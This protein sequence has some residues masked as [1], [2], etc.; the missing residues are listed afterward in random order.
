MLLAL[1]AIGAFGLWTPDKDRAWLERK[2]LA[3]PGDMVQVAGMPLQ[4]RDRGP[5]TAPAA[6][7]I[8]GFG[9]SLQTWDALHPARVDR[10]VRIAPDG[11]ASPGFAHGQAP[12]VPSALTLMACA[13]LS[14]ADSGHLPQEETP[15]R[16]IAAVRDFLE[17]G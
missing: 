7:L 4:V 12:K 1:L 11:F 16:T 17:P 10:L 3:D 8:H 14:I 13:L 15:A 9:A 2:D 6:I 5:R